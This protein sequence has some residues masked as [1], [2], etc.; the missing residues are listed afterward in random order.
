[1]DLVALEEIKRLKHRYLRCVDTKDWDGLADTLAVDATADYGTPVYGSPLHFDGRDAL[2]AFLRDKLGEGMTTTHFATQPEIDIDGAEAVG[3]WAFQDTVIVEAHRLVITGAAYYEDRYR[4][5]D[6]GR[7]RI[8]HTGYERIYEAMSSLDDL[9]SFRLTANR[10][11][12][13]QV[14]SREG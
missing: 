2:V 13:E 14:A 12:V 4:R 9:P 6:G 3:R 5:A 8:T 10:W 7:W 1:M 11:A